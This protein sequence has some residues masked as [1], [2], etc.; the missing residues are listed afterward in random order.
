MRGTAAD[1]A[2]SEPGRFVDTGL[3]LKPVDLRDKRK[4]NHTAIFL[5]N[6]L[7]GW[8][9]VGRVVALVWTATED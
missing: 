9:F 6:L 8:T 1:A 5:L 4:R 3:S 2:R 7:L